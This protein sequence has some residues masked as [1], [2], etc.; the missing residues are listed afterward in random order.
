MSLGTITALKL[1]FKRRG[2]LKRFSS[3]LTDNENLEN[4]IKNIKK[5]ILII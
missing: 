5:Q 3:R 1:F 2:R 4:R